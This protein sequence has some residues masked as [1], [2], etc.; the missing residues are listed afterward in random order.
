MGLQRIA[1]IRSFG[2][3]FDFLQ[4]WRSQERNEGAL[5]R[6]CGNGLFSW[7]YEGWSRAG[8]P[9]R[10][11]IAALKSHKPKSAIP[12][13]RAVIHAWHATVTDSHDGFLPG[14]VGFPSSF[15]FTIGQKL[16]ALNP[17]SSA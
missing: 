6:K 5:A 8:V 14:S 2:G 11:L 3:W 9:K 4:Q 7:S 17:A 13:A 16:A 15:H 12:H 10:G 1:G